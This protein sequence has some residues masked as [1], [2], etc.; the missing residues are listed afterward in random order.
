TYR[1]ERGHSVAPVAP[2]EPFDDG[3]LLALEANGIRY[4]KEFR[5]GD[6]VTVEY[7]LE[8]DATLFSEWNLSLPDGPE[9][10][11]PTFTLDHGCCSITTGRFTLRCRHDADDVWV[12]RLY[13]VSNTEG[14]VELAPQ[15]WSLV[16]SA[17]CEGRGLRTL[18][19]GWTVTG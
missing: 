15:G 4:G 2:T 12:E 7:R 17:G 3:L 6:G 10:T 18:T 1:R 11:P 19:L 13:S 9:G 5:F 16:F 14:G 8:S